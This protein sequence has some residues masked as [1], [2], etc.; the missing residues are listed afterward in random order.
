MSIIDYI[1][2]FEELSQFS[3]HMVSRNELKVNQFLQGL[4][5]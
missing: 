3:L 4:K 2:K 5:V 1:K